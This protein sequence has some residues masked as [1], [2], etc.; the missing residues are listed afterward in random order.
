M[1]LKEIKISFYADV[2]EK[3]MEEVTRVFN[4]CGAEIIEHNLPELRNIGFFEVSEVET[5]RKLL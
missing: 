4:K 2:N 5:G 3:D 1:E